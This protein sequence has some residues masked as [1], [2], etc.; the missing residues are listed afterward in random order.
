[1]IDISNRSL[2]NLDYSLFLQAVPNG[3]IDLAIIDPPYNLRKESWDIFPSKY[4]FFTFTYDW[5][6]GKLIPT[7]KCTASLYIFNTH[8]IQHTYL[9]TLWSVDWFIRIG[10]VWDKRDGFNYCKRRFMNW[11]EIILFFTVSSDYTFNSDNIR[12]PYE[13]EN[14][15]QHAVQKGILKNGKRWFPDSRGKLCGDVWKFSSERLKCK[16]NGK[17]Q[18]LIHATP[19]PLD[20]IERMVLASSNPA[21]VILDC[22]VGTGTHSFGSKKAQQIVYL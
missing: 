17:T 22:F 13:S 18:K 3:S 14:R 2:H 12:I 19:K 15:I 9:N 5:I 10:I 8:S 6:G 11:Q 21:D 4:D 1:M 16:I 7:L 20:S